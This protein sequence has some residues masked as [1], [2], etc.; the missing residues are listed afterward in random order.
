MLL[1]LLQWDGKIM[2]KKAKK[3]GRKLGIKV[4]PYKMNLSK[5]YA[6]VK[7]LRAEVAKMRKVLN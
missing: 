3:R 4:G 1:A 7:E 2:V 5:L 6:E